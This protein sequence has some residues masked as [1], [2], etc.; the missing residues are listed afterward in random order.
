M[1]SEQAHDV[2]WRGDG[3]SDIEEK[4]QLLPGL[5]S[6]YPPCRNFSSASAF[7]V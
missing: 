3:E 7:F 6:T 4:L 2:I 1:R 5:T